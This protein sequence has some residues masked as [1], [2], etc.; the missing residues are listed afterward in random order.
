MIDKQLID[1]AV[2]TNV[3]WSTKRY[4]TVFVMFVKCDNKYLNFSAD[5]FFNFLGPGGRAVN[6]DSLIYK[7]TYGGGKYLFVFEECREACY[8]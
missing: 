3:N 6:H 7:M 1:T 8:A 5:I 4:F 2:N